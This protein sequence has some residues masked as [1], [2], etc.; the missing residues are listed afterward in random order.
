MSAL[1]EVE[2][3][4][5]EE[6]PDLILSRHQW[7]EYLQALQAGARYTAFE[8]QF[9]VLTMLYLPDVGLELVDNCPLG[10]LAA[11]DSLRLNRKLP[12]GTFAITDRNLFDAMFL[13]N[14]S[15]ET[16]AEGE[17][18]IEDEGTPKEQLRNGITS[19]KYLLPTELLR[20]LEVIG[21]E[22]LISELVMLAEL[23]PCYGEEEQGYFLDQLRADVDL[24][25]PRGTYHIL[26][27]WF[28][29]FL[30]THRSR[31][32]IKHTTDIRGSGGRRGPSRRQQGAT[33]RRRE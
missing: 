9:A 32:Q 17:R 23:F 24:Q 31:R 33:R 22:A 4:S 8:W 30:T 18:T 13:V 26:V 15:T 6:F 20:Q 7:Q 1:T 2:F 27:P 21:R 25:H 3:C 5:F 29:T 16:S 19:S 28:F 12:L 14:A 10:M 11:Y